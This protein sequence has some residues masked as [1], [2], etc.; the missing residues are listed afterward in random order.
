MK[1]PKALA[2]ARTFPVPIGSFSWGGNS[3]RHKGWF[4]VAGFPY[5]ISNGRNIWANDSIPKM[6]RAGQ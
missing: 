3:Y 5:C 6:D 2:N 4:S 1:L